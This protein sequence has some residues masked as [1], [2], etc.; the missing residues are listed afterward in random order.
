MNHQPPHAHEPKC[1]WRTRHG[2]H[3]LNL[4]QSNDL[5]FHKQ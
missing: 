2:A 4:D 1:L 5:D 3:R